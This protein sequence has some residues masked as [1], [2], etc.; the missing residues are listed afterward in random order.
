MKKPGFVPAFFLNAALR[1]ASR[2]SYSHHYAM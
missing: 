1:A 2:K